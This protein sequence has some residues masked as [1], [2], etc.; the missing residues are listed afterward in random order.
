MTSART[1]AVIRTAH[2]SRRRARAVRT[3][4]DRR[5]CFLRYCLI[6]LSTWPAPSGIVCARPENARIHRWQSTRS[7]I[8]GSD[9]GSMTMRRAQRGLRLIPVLLLL[10]VPLRLTGQQQA[11]APSSWADEVLKQE[12]YQQPPKELADAV[13]APRHLNTTLSS[14]SPDK[15]WFLEDTPDGPVEMKT[16]SRPYHEL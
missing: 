1:A 16:F 3:G 8:H 12:S 4:R 15:K 11:A 10:L 2:H 9:G 13:L 7:R 5:N 14:L 6:R